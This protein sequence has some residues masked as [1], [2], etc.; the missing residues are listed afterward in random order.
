MKCGVDPGV[1]WR[2]VWSSG[3]EGAAALVETANVTTEL[4]WLDREDNTNS[5]EGAAALADALKVDSARSS[6]HTVFFKLG[7][8]LLYANTF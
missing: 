1:A 6:L 7:T 2:D 4:M 3:D 5:D 8:E